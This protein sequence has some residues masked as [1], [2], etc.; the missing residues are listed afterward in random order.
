MG[1]GRRQLVSGKGELLPKLSPDRCPADPVGDAQRSL[2]HSGAAW[3]V[4]IAVQRST[5]KGGAERVSPSVASGFACALDGLDGRTRAAPPW[6]APRL[7]ASAD[8]R[9]VEQP[10]SREASEEN[11]MPA[12]TIEAPSVG[13]VRVA[14]RDL[15]PVR[16]P[17]RVQPVEQPASLCS[18]A[19]HHIDRAVS[20]QRTPALRVYTPP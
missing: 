6:T 7:S 13:P 17:H 19:A 18:I 15:L 14:N 20:R 10:R 3:V 16:R 8:W 12:A 1:G 4:I 11:A 5:R 9:P 2:R